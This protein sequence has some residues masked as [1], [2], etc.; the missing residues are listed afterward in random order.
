LTTYL[1][2]YT[3]SKMD[4]KMDRTRVEFIAEECVAV[5]LRLLTRAVTKIYNRALQ[6][7]RVTISQMNILVAVSCMKQARQ[8]DVC[9]ALHLDKS[10]L[11]RD[12]ERMEAKGWMRSTEGVDRRTGWLSVTLAGKKLLERAFPA[13][14]QA[15]HHAKALLNE[16]DIAGIDRAIRALRPGKN[17]ETE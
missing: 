10:T 3:I 15:Q 14:D 1:V 17:I 9:R 8:Q 12:V 6:P 7:Y 11:S 4:K 16:K 13:W 5:R 2:V